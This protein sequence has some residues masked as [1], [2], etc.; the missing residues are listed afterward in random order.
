[1]AG[2]VGPSKSEER[3][4]R[5]VELERTRMFR[6]MLADYLNCH[7]GIQHK[8]EDNKQTKRSGKGDTE[9][10]RESSSKGDRE[11]EGEETDQ[12]SDQESSKICPYL[13]ITP[14]RT[15]RTNHESRCF[16]FGRKTRRLIQPSLAHGDLT[17]IGC[18]L[19]IEKTI[20]NSEAR[21]RKIKNRRR[22][23][24]YSMNNPARIHAFHFDA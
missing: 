17:T 20:P 4:S 5:S 16:E 6:P 14:I 12:E 7:V 10:T 13:Q 24:Q 18:P 19:H 1:M 11:R 21:N 8:S 9:Q 22:G 2:E 15:K 23:Q 3:G